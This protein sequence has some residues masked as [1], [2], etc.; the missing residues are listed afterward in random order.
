MP[1]PE[2]K[3]QLKAKRRSLAKRAEKRRY[4]FELLKKYKAK[5]RRTSQAKDQFL[6]SKKQIADKVKAFSEKYLDKDCQFQARIEYMKSQMS[7][8]DYAKTPEA[9]M[10]SIIDAVV[11]EGISNL[12]DYSG[13]IE[14]FQKDEDQHLKFADNDFR[15]IERQHLINADNAFKKADSTINELLDEEFGMTEAFN[16]FYSDVKELQDSVKEIVSGGL[17]T[18]SKFYYN[19]RLTEDV[20]EIDK[21]TGKEVTVKKIREPITRKVTKEIK[22][23]KGNV[24]ETKDYPVEYVQMNDVPLFSHEPCAEDIQQGHV[25]DC[26]FIAAMSAVAESNPELIRNCM[27]DNGDGTVSVRLYDKDGIGVLV[28]VNKS[29]PC[30]KV[31]DEYRTLYARG[32]LWVSILEKAYVQSGIAYDL[33]ESFAKNETT[34]FSGEEQKDIEFNAYEK[35]AGGRTNDAT[36]ILLGESVIEDANGSSNQVYIPPKK[37]ISVKQPWEN[38]YSED[39][40]RLFKQLDDYHKKGQVI[41]CGIDHQKNIPDD[42]HYE[43]TK[44]LPVGHAYSILDVKQRIVKRNGQDHL[45]SFV[46]VKN[47]HSIGGRTYD[48]NGKP[49]YEPNPEV[50][51]ESWVELRDFTRTFSSCFSFIYDESAVER[52]ESRIAGDNMKMYGDAIKQACT[53]IIKSDPWYVLNSSEKFKNL[54]LSAIELQKEYEKKKPDP[55]QM[56]KKLE[57]FFKKSQEYKKDRDSRTPENSKDTRERSMIRYQLVE[58]IG[59]FEGI[60]KENQKGGMEYVDFDTLKEQA[61]DFALDDKYAEASRAKAATQ[62]GLTEKKQPITREEIANRITEVEQ[63]GL[64]RI[65]QGMKD[66]KLSEI[67]KGVIEVLV[68][69]AIKEKQNNLQ[70]YDMDRQL[71]DDA[72]ERLTEKFDTK[73]GEAFKTIKK[74]KFMEIIK[75]DNIGEKLFET[76]EKELKPKPNVLENKGNELQT[77]PQEKTSNM[78]N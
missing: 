10:E 6:L 72:V 5:H 18:N 52:V 44:G 71:S 31:G 26:Y 45:L 25:G 35:I 73:L 78:L 32:S 70:P 48:E 20:K 38:G 77:G 34:V 51:G 29:V 14:L 11:N 33:N 27:K 4:D 37:A 62:K 65:T 47:P 66:N 41:T 39:E 68:S 13:I 17:D 28:T 75:A 19:I 61:L 57:K 22:D 3:E 21:E 9:K 49:Q 8:E 43:A 15:K 42:K 76:I 60:Y 30:Y 53:E 67:K 40:Q 50:P 7:N 23:E 74:D 2:K 54:K 59:L 16:D 56:K 1:N 36:L 55:E 46:K 24:I 12:S 64:N 69:R 58:A 63:K